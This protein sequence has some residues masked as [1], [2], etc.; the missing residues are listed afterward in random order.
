MLRVAAAF[1]IVCFHSRIAGGEV[2]Q[3]FY[4]GLIVFIIVSVWFCLARPDRSATQHFAGILRI[5]VPWLAWMIVYRLKDAY[6][7]DPA[8][9]DGAIDVLRL[10]TGASVH[11]WYVPFIAAV[12]TLLWWLRRRCGL[13]R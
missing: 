1:G 9:E 2:R 5:A 13:R 6:A 7:G 4:A 10:F 11:L 8:A 12:T 3:A